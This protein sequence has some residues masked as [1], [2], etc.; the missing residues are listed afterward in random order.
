QLIADTRSNA[1]KAE[2][3]SH[4]LKSLPDIKQ[5]KL[6]VRFF[7]EGAF[8]AIDKKRLAIGHKTIAEAACGFL[9]LDYD[10]VFRACK[11]A[12]GSSS[13]AIEKLMEAWPIGIQKR[14]PKLH[15]LS[16]IA[17]FF[18]HLAE[19]KSKEEKLQEL[20][21]LWSTLTPLEIKYAIRVMH[22]YSLRIGFEEKSILR[23]I[24][25][26]FSQPLEDIRYA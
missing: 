1:E 22:Q 6:A 7:G 4:Y 25:S 14:N 18:E 13:E 12:T 5:Q 2:I 10:Y 21:R 15:S 26:A 17:D 3:C 20:H 23:A 8:A 11:T 16:E 19:I 9:E 24:A